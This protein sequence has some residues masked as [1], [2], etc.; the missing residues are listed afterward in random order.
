MPLTH[1]SL[2]LTSLCSRN[3]FLINVL[4]DV[5]SCE[6][7][8]DLLTPTDIREKYNL[9]VYTYE[10]PSEDILLQSTYILEKEIAALGRV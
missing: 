10:L 3:H 4:G 8:E 6:T 7:I 1:P 5:R 2:Q 9:L